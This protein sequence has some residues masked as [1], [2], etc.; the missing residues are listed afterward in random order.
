M[1][2]SAKSTA[3]T[4]TLITTKHCV[5]TMCFI[6]SNIMNLFNINFR[7]VIVQNN[8]NVSWNVI[9]NQP[10]RF[11]ACISPRWRV[12]A[13]G[14]LETNHEI[15]DDMK[16]AKT[17]LQ[18]LQYQMQLHMDNICVQYT[19]KNQ[20]RPSCQTIHIHINI[21]MCHKKPFQNVTECN[22]GHPA[23]TE[24]NHNI[25][26]C[27]DAHQQQI[28]EPN[29]GMWDQQTYYQNN[30]YIRCVP[31]GIMQ[32]MTHRTNS[33]WDYTFCECFECKYQNEPKLIIR[34]I[35]QHQFKL[36]YADI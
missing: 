12:V 7:P 13:V 21:Y 11:C 3:T 1:Q 4:T 17:M 34:H 31:A 16:L 23:Q 30:K 10:K 15:V 35:Q 6:V 14:L 22:W 25:T 26:R 20:T 32:H 33:N 5:P 8:A 27:V 29:D 18:S 2:I 28:L 36:R 19:P 24:T 9:G